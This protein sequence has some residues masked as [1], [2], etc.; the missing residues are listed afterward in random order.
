M[1]TL[2]SALGILSLLVIGGVLGV[3]GFGLY[4]TGGPRL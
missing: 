4:L 3:A 1:S 2:L